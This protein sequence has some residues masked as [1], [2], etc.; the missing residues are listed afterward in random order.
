MDSKIHITPPAITTPSIAGG[1]ARLPLFPLIILGAGIYL[2]WFGVHYWR[3]DQKY[4]TGPVKS[5]L[6]GKG[7]PP[8]TNKTSEATIEAD[9]SG[10]ESNAPSATGTTTAYHNPLSATLTPERI[11]QGV[12]YG[13]S[14]D[15]YAMGDGTVVTTH[16]SGWPGGTF[17]CIHL[18]SGRYV[19]YAENITPAVLPTVNVKAGQVIGHAT[20]GGIEIGWA[21]PPGAGTSKANAAG[22]FDGSH[23]T[24]FG[25]DMSDTI[26]AAGG[27]AGVLVPP[28]SGTVAW[29][30]AEGGTGSGDP[31]SPPPSNYGK[32][33]LVALWTSNG[34]SAGTADVAQA[35]A[36]AESSGNPHA[37]S[38]NP[39][40]GTNVGLWQLDTKGK[41]AEYTVPQLLDP[42]T[43]AKVAVSG[44][45]N[46]KDWSAW[47]TY[48]SG[49]YKRYL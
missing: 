25:K 37:V 33:E 20:G 15:L 9:V 18:A 22:Q 2:L 40:G 47:A 35:V 39:D 24:A 29:S 42:A 28:V 19:Y 16:N 23:S 43:N 26:A 21:E 31:G 32:T 44:S 3:T 5:I 48:T 41:G 36:Q 46:G 17:I 7:L 34:G 13:G 27:K 49:A 14:G 8:V 45:G 1:H 10:A 12:D 38:Q 6:T 11:D 30:T 4:P